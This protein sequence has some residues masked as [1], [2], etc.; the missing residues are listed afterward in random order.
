M[1]N[2]FPIG[3]WYRLDSVVTKAE[4][5][6]GVVWFTTKGETGGGMFNLDHS[7]EERSAFWWRSGVWIFG[8][9]AQNDTILD[10]AAKE[11]IQHLKN[12]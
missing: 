12:L 7:K 4:D 9:D 6:V 2:T 3:N 8:V 11:L 5:S 10:Q 1:L